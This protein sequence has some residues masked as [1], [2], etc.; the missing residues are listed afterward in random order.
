M[1]RGFRGRRARPALLLTLAALAV[2]CGG[3]DEAVE[4]SAEPVE[5]APALSV[6]GDDAPELGG[7]DTSGTSTDESATGTAPEDATG[8]TPP[9]ETPPS[10]AAPDSPEND[11]PP[12]PDSPAERFEDFCAENPGAC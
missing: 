4:D 8:G 5:K 12:P 3:D 10:E 7:T 2:G 11:T 6:P 9:E 1:T